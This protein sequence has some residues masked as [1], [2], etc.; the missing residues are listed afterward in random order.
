MVEQLVSVNTWQHARTLCESLAATMLGGTPPWV[1]HLL[2]HDLGGAEGHAHPLRHW[3]AL[4]HGAVEE[5]LGALHHQVSGDGASTGRFTE[6]RDVSSV[7]TKLTVQSKMA[8]AGETNASEAM[9]LTLDTTL[10]FE[11]VARWCW[12]YAMLSCTQRMEARWSKMPYRPVEPSVRLA[13][14]ELPKK[15]NTPRLIDG[16]QQWWCGSCVRV[17]FACSMARCTRLHYR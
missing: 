16:D 15:P 10:C 1:T 6:D 3:A 2:V 12:T 8:A 5:A 13:N 9:V 17:K 7:A 14:S 11:F 4:H